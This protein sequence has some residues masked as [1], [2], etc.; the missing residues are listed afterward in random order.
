MVWNKSP[1]HIPLPAGVDCVNCHTSTTS[2]V[3]P[4][5]MSHSSVS[6]AT[7]VS[8][9]NSSYTSEGSKGALGTASYTGH[10]AIGSQDCTTCHTAAGTKSFTSWAGAALSLIHI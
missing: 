9:H 8:C 2:F 5:T 4:Y 7:C 6:G 10:V 3:T 1:P